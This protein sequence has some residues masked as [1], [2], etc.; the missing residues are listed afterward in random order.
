MIRVD[1]EALQGYAPTFEK[2]KGTVLYSHLF[3]SIKLLWSVDL[4]MRNIFRWKGNVEEP[5]L[6]CFGHCCFVIAWFRLMPVVIPCSFSSLMKL[7]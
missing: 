6:V 4:N 2:H 3:E 7:L 1:S 5:F